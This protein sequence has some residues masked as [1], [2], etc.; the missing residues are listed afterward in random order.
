MC[1]HIK[2]YFAMLIYLTEIW[3]NG[4]L[5]MYNMLHIASNVQYLTFL[6]VYIFSITE[7][8]QPVA[9]NVKLVAYM[10]SLFF[11]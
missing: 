1:T 2:S 3:S 4:L 5:Q 8:V 9:P 10:K 11:S 6:V 7:L